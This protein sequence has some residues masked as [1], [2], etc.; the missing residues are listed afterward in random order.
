MAS[1]LRRA[2]SAASSAASSASSA[3]SATHS[4]SFLKRSLFRHPVMSISVVL[5]TLGVALPYYAYLIDSPREALRGPGRL[6]PYLDGLD[7]MERQRKERILKA[8]EGLDHEDPRIEALRQHLHT[9]PKY[10]PQ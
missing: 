9:S 2:R 3:A 5:G 6:Q 10:K 1:L 8:M 7:E 4:N